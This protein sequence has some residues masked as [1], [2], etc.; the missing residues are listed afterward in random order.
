[1]H[2]DKEAYP[3]IVIEDASVEFDHFGEIALLQDV[4]RTATIRTRIP[5][6]FLTL[7]RTQLLRLMESAPQ[8]RPVLDQEIGRRLA[9]SQAQKEMAVAAPH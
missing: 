5:S 4:P 7:S 2:R 6:L 8:L 3:P 1:M 9:R